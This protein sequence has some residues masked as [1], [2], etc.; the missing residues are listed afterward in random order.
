[1][2]ADESS[3]ENTESD[4][5]SQNSESNEPLPQN[6]DEAV[7]DD[8]AIIRENSDGGPQIISG[9]PPITD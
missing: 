1:M 7:V 5:V 6:S 4:T 2:R 9:E 8:K 3:T